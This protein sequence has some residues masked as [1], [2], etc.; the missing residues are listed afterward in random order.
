M[1]FSYRAPDSYA[2]P[3][4]ND[5]T[6]DD[7][8]I[9]MTELGTYRA[10]TGAGGRA[11]TTLILRE[12]AASSYQILAWR[13]DDA[14]LTTDFTVT[15]DIAPPPRLTT[16][17][18]TGPL[19]VPTTFERISGNDQTGLPGTVLADPF[20]VEVRDQNGEPLEGV[21]VTF[22]VVTG[23][24]AVSVAASRTDS[25]GRVESTL[26]L[27]TDPGVNKVQVSVEGIFQIAVFNAWKASHHPFGADAGR[28]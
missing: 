3:A 21:T 26:T 6:S 25:D 16:T 7:D 5:D 1:L 4:P 27:G 19:P 13:T 20:V 12:D 17:T 22:A 18:P 10:T 15:V 2:P 8:A 24:G 11:Q 28:R 9:D 14:S 23:G